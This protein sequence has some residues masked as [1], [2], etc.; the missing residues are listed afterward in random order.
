MFL[1]FG[2]PRSGTTL[3]KEALCQNPG[4]TIPHE[5][6]FIIPLAFLVDRIKNPEVGR[7]LI[8]QMIVSTNAF[9]PSIG[10][11]LSPNEVEE[12]VNR[13]PYSLGAILTELYRA[14]AI[15]SYS[16]IAGD[17]SPNDL[18]FA[19]ILRKAGLFDSG[20][21][22][23]HIVRDIRDVI[24]SLKGT[25]WAPRDIDTYFPR[26]WASA[27][28]NLK[29][30]TNCRADSYFFMRFEDFVAEPQHYLEKI[31]GFLCVKFSKAML[32]WPE[33]GCDLKHLKHHANLGQYPIIDRC[34]AWK[35]CNTEFDF[36]KISKQA[37]EALTE[38][39]YET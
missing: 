35:L 9:S 26:I 24:L 34:Y 1:I 11:F 17:K 7:R 22:F 23:I 29:Q 20:V 15:K 18:G 10:R 2:S 6:D 13:S 16:S 28:L 8:S 14:V 12:I 19:G 4:I 38:F 32:N 37:G 27:N 21:K 31:C 25:S 5:T 33:M 3:L 36:S 30:F 39:G